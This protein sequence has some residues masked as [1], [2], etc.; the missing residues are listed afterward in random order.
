VSAGHDQGFRPL[1][2]PGQPPAALAF[3]GELA[4]P[5]VAVALGQGGGNRGHGPGKRCV[6]VARQ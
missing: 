6:G 2:L 4:R 1:T 5:E 3:L